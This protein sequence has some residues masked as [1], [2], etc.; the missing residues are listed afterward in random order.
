LAAGEISVA[1][2]AEIVKAPAAHHDE[3]TSVARRG[4]LQPVREA[5]RWRV[6]AEIPPEELHDK[7]HDA[8]QFT[9]WINDLG[10]VAFSGEV[11]PE[12]GVPWV[13]RLDREIDRV[14]RTDRT[15]AREHVAAEVLLNTTGD[16][17]DNK[18]D[19]E[20]CHLIG[21][22]PIPVA[23]AREMMRDAFLKVVL[24]DGVNIHTIKHFGRHRPA[25][26][27]TAL[28]LGRPPNFAGASCKECGRKYNLQW[29]HID[30]VGNDGPTSL[31]NLQPLCIPDHVIKTERDRKAGKLKRRPQ[32]P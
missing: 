6:L 31:A 8:M 11:P 9:H 4:A 20:P 22:G 32:G 15:R 21:G 10:N 28:D 16:T 29:D 3:L 19:G 27:Q 1:Q 25:A 12:L 23:I 7:Q 24:H 2:A 18:I 14:W 13:N 17:A 5:A 30:P 26:L